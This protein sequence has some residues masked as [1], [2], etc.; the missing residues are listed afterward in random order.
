MCVR[1]CVSARVGVSCILYVVCMKD[2]SVQARLEHARYLRHCLN[3]Y[4]CS[5]AMAISLGGSRD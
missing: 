2:V 3:G 1:A 5:S 4:Y